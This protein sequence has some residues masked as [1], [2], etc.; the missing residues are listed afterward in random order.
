MG[1]PPIHFQT[2]ALNPVPGAH[3]TPVYIVAHPT[4][5][6]PGPPRVGHQEEGRLAAPQGTTAAAAAAV[7]P[8][9]VETYPPVVLTPPLSVT[10]KADPLVQDAGAMPWHANLVRLHT[11]PPLHTLAA[12]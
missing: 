3:A 10:V 2:P 8:E 7:P 11:L 12:A 5:V 4:L 6:V 9:A 1:V